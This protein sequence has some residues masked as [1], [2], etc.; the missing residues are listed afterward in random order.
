MLSSIIITGGNGKSRVGEALKIRQ[1]YIHYSSFQNDPDTYILDEEK[2]I[3]INAVR[4]LQIWLQKKPYQALKKIVLIKKAENL[5]IPAQNAFL[6]ILEE[7]PKNSIIILTTQNINLLLSTITSRCQIIR[8]PL[9]LLK[10]KESKYKKNVLNLPINEKITLSYKIGKNKDEAQRWL[11][12][13]RNFHHQQLRQGD[14]Q[15]WKTLAKINQA[16]KMLEANVNPRLV[17][18]YLL[19]NAKR[20][21]INDKPAKRAGPPRRQITSLADEATNFQI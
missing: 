3:S 9:I 13:Q 6:K 20:L 2:K 11:K 17:I 8:L 5:T 19:L 7:P 21:M 16:E 10:E 1:K 14:N 15:A 18:E 4:H 12:I